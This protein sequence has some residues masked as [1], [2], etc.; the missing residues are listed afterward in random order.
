MSRPSWLT[1]QVTAQEAGSTLETLLRQTL[2]IS[3][4]RLQKLTRSR[5]I[6]L[7]QKPTFLAKVVQSGDVISVQTQ[8]SDAPGLTPLPMPLTIVHEDEAVLVL[9][10]PPGILVHPTQASHTQTLAHGVAYYYQQQG[11]PHPIHAVH[12]LDRD[13][14]GLVVFAQ[15]PLSHAA[16][17]RQL[18]AAKDPHLATQATFERHYLALVAGQVTEEV[19]VIDAPITKSADCDLRQVSTAGDAARTRFQVVERYAQATLLKLM[20]ETGRTHQIRVHLLHL[21]HP[22]LG[23]RQYGHEGCDRINR[24][25][26]HAEHLSFGH[27]TTGTTMTFSAP[28]PADFQQLMN[29]L[30]QD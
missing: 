11:N 7:N 30:R 3:G 15:N 24:Q 26:L 22:V 16:L 5:G 23:D 9:N 13:T 19:G 12:R 14:S 28:V 10:K 2:K 29:R 17:D 1:H 4:R 21:G 18:R 20:L 6:R 8:T 25:A 27:P